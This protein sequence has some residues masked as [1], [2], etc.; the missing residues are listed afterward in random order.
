LRTAGRRTACSSLEADPDLRRA[1]PGQVRNRRVTQ[2]CT[3]LAGSRLQS[4][5]GHALQ[6][7]ETHLQVGRHAGE[8]APRARPRTAPHMYSQ[9]LPPRPVAGS[10]RTGPPAPPGQH[11]V[12]RRRS[13]HCPGRARRSDAD[14]HDAGPGA[15]R[16]RSGPRR[17][18]RRP[19]WPGPAHAQ[20]SPAGR[21]RSAPGTRATAT[22]P[23]GSSCR[24]PAHTPPPVSSPTPVNTQKRHR[25]RHVR[26]KRHRN[27]V[28]SK[29][30]VKRHNTQK[31]HIRCVEIG[32]S[33]EY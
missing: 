12:A 7:M 4:S 22:R 25:T 26:A 10:P 2:P 32:C 14:R 11:R 17:R 18:S 5:G 29:R 24:V 21:G 13:S 15:A 33:H 27:N 3:A 30:H 16:I 9:A 19:A 23:A 20:Q 8:T 1:G 6:A 28:H 31:R